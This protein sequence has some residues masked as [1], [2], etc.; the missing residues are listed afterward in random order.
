MRIRAIIFDVGGVLNYGFPDFKHCFKTHGITLR[1][2]LWVDNNC[3]KLLDD[4]ATGNYGIDEN[5]ARNFFNDIEAQGVIQCSI[6]YEQFKQAWNAAI[7]CLNYELIDELSTL[8]EQGY[9]LYT[10]SDTNIL[11]RE[12]A[13]KLYQQKHPNAT[14]RSLFDKCY[15]SHETGQ[16]K[17]FSGEKANQAWLQILEENGLQPQECL[18]IDDKQKYVEKAIG[19]GLF[20]LHYQSGA[21]SKTVFSALAE[22]NSNNGCSNQR[23]FTRAPLPFVN[24]L[25]TTPSIH[26]N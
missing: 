24:E 9:R 19:L 1:E 17:G 7:I 26:V 14:L 13:E 3:K 16:Y 15:F 11:H 12:Y 8:K 6:S 4:F 21:T 25:T 22:I 23:F 5:A 2:D 10:L 18:F 20:G